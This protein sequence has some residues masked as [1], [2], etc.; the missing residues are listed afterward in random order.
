VKRFLRSWSFVSDVWR[1][2]SWVGGGAFQSEGIS[3]LRFGRKNNAEL[4]GKR[5]NAEHTDFWT[6]KVAK[7]FYAIEPNICKS[8]IMSMHRVGIEPN[9]VI[10]FTQRGSPVWL[11]MGL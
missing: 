9:P 5:G 4:L 2:V 7:Q 3:A 10:N 6:V 11:T 1:R 8:L